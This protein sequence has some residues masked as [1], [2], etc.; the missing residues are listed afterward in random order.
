MQTQTSSI[1]T[2]GNAVKAPSPGTPFDLAL[3][4]N[5]MA[6]LRETWLEHQVNPV[7]DIETRGGPY[8]HLNDS[9]LND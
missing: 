6:E 5:Q 8:S 2:P 9:P 1:Q 4:E 7:G 3:T